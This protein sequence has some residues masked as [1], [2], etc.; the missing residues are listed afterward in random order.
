MLK[1]KSVYEAVSSRDGLRIL[2][3][4]LP[5]RYL[6]AELYDVWMRNLG[7]SKPLLRARRSGQLNL[8][9]FRRS[10]YK[11]LLQEQPVDR[12]N[13]GF[14]SCGHKY[15]LRLIKH[16]ATRQNVTLLCTCSADAETCHRYLLADLI[17]SSR[18]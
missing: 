14:K 16:L 6:S 17:G 13:G 7:P 8:R 9:E 4:R 2:T 11:E 1:T 10:Y 3:T 15:S 5:S 12:G 18:I